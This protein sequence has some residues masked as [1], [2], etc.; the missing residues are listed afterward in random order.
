MFSDSEGEIFQRAEECR[1]EARRAINAEE[2]AAWL[3]L[4]EE[5]LRLAQTTLMSEEPLEMELER[6]VA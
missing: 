3:S 2:R 4:A 5:W 6:E 1:L